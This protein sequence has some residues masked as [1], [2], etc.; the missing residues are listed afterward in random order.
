MASSIEGK[1]V[2]VLMPT[3]NDWL[4]V[5][6]LIPRIDEVLAP[7]K[8]RAHVVIV[9]DGSYD[10][11]GKEVLDTVS[12]STIERIDE[13]VLTCNQG[14]Q[15]TIAI[16]VA[17]VAA[18]E[19]G[20]YLLV[21]DSDNEDNPEDIPKLLQACADTGDRKIIFA[22][23][24]KR[25][26]G[27]TFRFYYQLYRGLYRM[28]TNTSISMGNF[29]V[30]PWGMVLRL[31]SLSALWN[32]F[33]ASII[34]AQMPFEMIRCVRGKRLFGKT[35]MNIVSLVTHAF[36][37]FSI[38]SDVV[39][40]RTIIFTLLLSVLIAISAFGLIWLRL[41]TDIPMIGWTSIILSLLA[42]ALIQ[43]VMAAGLMLFLTL[44]MRMQPA[45][46]PAQEYEKFILSIAT[47]YPLDD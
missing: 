38:F 20:D 27:L 9:D 7:I 47:L 2:V 37:A 42:I 12:L 16:G 5:A 30:I 24:S 10:L 19:K 25:S 31:A 41:F 33:P 1:T 29:S 34:R 22:E 40:V 35:K 43:I 26:E 23:R 14:N 6:H 18:Q 45:L 3:Y 4:S 8:V 32:H 11:H 28:L 44:F 21:M 39:A 17:H 46:I 36:S 15:R 13:V